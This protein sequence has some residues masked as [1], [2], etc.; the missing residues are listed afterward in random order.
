[1]SD[2]IA[3]ID[4]LGRKLEVKLLN[5][6]DQLDLFEAAQGHTEY[7]RWFEIAS[8]IFTCVSIDGVPLPKPRKPDDFKKNVALLKNEGMEAIFKALSPNK[9]DED[10]EAE[11]SHAES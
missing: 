4:A 7:K 11:K 8:I 6:T 5:I 9:E 1:M 10:N 2:I 3:A